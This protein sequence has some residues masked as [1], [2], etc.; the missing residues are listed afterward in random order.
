[1]TAPCRSARSVRHRVRGGDRRGFSL[2]EATVSI[3]IMSVLTVAMGSAVVIASRAVPDP[4]RA[5]AAHSTFDAL[6]R[7]SEELRYAISIQAVSATSIRFTVADRNG[8]LSEEVITYE[9][10]SAT[11]KLS[12]RYNSAEPAT[13]L[14][15]VAAFAMAIEKDKTTTIQTVSGSVN[16]GNVLLSSF[17]GWTGVTPSV[18][19]FTLSASS[20]VNTYFKID[21]V[22]LPANTTRLEISSVR[23]KIK[24]SLTITGTT[25]T[26]G[27]YL[28]ASAGGPLPS[29]TQ[30][31][32]GGTCDVGILSTVWPSTFVDVPLSGVVFS[33]PVSEL[34]LVVKG[35]STGGLQIQYY[36]STSAPVNTPVYLSTTDS[37]SSWAPT[38]NQ[39]QNDLVFEV[40]GNYSYP[41]TQEL[42][43]DTYYLRACTI[44][45][46]TGSPAST[47][48]S[49]VR[50][51]NKPVVPGP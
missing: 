39:N 23:L 15:N 8:D 29:N 27:I 37:G 32:S 5:A 18:M 48:Q 13:V 10:N 33:S 17:S 40:Y 14:E 44:T 36:N 49:T 25:A 9:W 38:K 42:S 45:C 4:K 22:T 50:V 28:P 43:T 7:L 47:F 31:G 26:A 19:P 11:K 41:A 12:R 35:S 1:M 21:R 24:R 30:V 3:G 46:Q 34:N 20:W 6:A 16:S 51:L 2:A